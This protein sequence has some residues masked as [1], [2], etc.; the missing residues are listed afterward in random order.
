MKI[1]LIVPY[2][3]IWP[4]WFPAFLL[5]CRYNPHVEWL[6][7][8]DCEAPSSCSDNVRFIPGTLHD[9]NRLA[10]DKLGFEVSLA[11][12]YKICDLRPAFGIVFADHLKESNFWGHCDVDVIWGDIRK[13]I[14]DDIL[15]NHDIISARKHHIAGH[16][17]LFRNS[18]TIN[19]IYTLFPKFEQILRLPEHTVFDER[20]MTPAVR[21][22]QEQNMLRVYWPRF[23][24]NF[25]HQKSDT[26]SRLGAYTRGW[27]WNHGR[28]FD[29]TEVE[30]EIMYLHFMTWKDTLKHID[31]G[32]ADDPA[33]F[34]IT[35]SG[36]YQDSG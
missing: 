21:K 7:F 20:G 24:F 34:H 32:Y 17:S 27:Y 26:P 13:F 23:L 6:F 14:T 36:I 10:T 18:K 12:P 9:L 1:T 8:T 3:G 28:L 4:V 11:R 16:F 5:S 22:L 35:A 2:F 25:A 29:Q 33:A 19:T 15:D 31:F 30:E